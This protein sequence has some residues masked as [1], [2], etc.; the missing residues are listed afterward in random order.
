MIRSFLA[1]KER[2][3]KNGR[4]LNFEE[5]LCT[6]SRFRTPFRNPD[7]RIMTA[8][9]EQSERGKRLPSPFQTPFLINSPFYST[10]PYPLPPVRREQRD[11]LRMS[12]TNSERGIF[13]C[14]FLGP[15]RRNRKRGKA[16]SSRRPCNPHDS[17]RCPE[18]PISG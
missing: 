13:P 18:T 8:D 12:E 9:A 3:R 5:R 16:L 4:G 17:G 11:R 15:E 1:R 7:K 14:S 10:K 2:N 6:L